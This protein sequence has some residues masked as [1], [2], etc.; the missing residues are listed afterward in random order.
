MTVVEQ[1]RQAGGG[2]AL[3]SGS[4]VVVKVGGATLG[5]ATFDGGGT[6]LEEVAALVHAGVRVVLVHGGGPLVTAWLDRLGV[7]TRFANGLRVTDEAALEAAAMVL[8]GLVNTGVVAGLSRQGVRALGLSG[9][10]NGLLRARQRPELGLVG[11]VERVDAAMLAQLLDAGTTPV[12]APL[13]LDAAGQ[14][15]N[16]NADDVTAAVAAALGADAALFLTDT[17]GVRDADGFPLET[18]DLVTAERLIADGAIVGGMIPKVRACLDALAGAH[19]ALILDGRAPG[20]LTGLLAGSVAGTTVTPHPPLPQAGPHPSPSR[21][22]GEQQPSSFSQ[23]E[24][25][26]QPSSFPPLPCAGEPVGL[27]A[28]QSRETN[29]HGAGVRVPGVREREARTYMHTFRR[30]P[31][32]LVRGQGTRVWDD[33]GRSYLDLVA[34]IAVNI[35]GHAHPAVAAAIARQSRTLLHASN[36]YYTLPQIELAELLV[37]MTGMDAVF[38]TNSGAEANEAAIKIARKWGKRHKDDAYEIITALNSFHGRTLATVAATG[39]PAYQAPFAPMPAGFTHVPYNDLDALDAAVGAQTAAVLLE[40][41]QGEG[42]IYPAAPGYLAAARRLCDERGALLMID[43]VQTGMGRTGTF[44]A[45]QGEGVAPDV[46]TLAKG[47][48][49][50]VPLGAALARG[51][52][53]VFEP[54]DHGS[55]QGGN[56]LACAAGAATLRALE[57]ENLLEHAA[58]VGAYFMQRLEELPARG[59]PVTEVRGRGLMLALEI[60]GD[61]ARVVTRARERGVLVNN[62][63]PTTVRM[64]PPLI[65]SRAEVEE[66]VAVLAAALTDVAGEGR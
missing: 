55:T 18:L 38:F 27:S 29:P 1:Q 62:T 41:I 53:N 30:Q 47:L 11:E 50:G 66:A 6:L 59:L 22:E 32:T 28:P 39:K 34:G 64:V 16:I 58:S 9:A 42:G 61:A 44:L 20:V 2:L 14:V 46:V 24:G 7:P 12:I 63:G 45:C 19:N 33:A 40:P 56:P 8:R 65:L 49:G 31:L 15:L 26:Q 43:E 5:G 4:T 35:L 25:V 60:D 17:P 10:D 57:Q 3:G 48:G 52:A 21:G 13:G 37:P 51:T 36:L 54:G 23:G